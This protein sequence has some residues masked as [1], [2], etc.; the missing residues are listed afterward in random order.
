MMGDVT[1]LPSSRP[2]TKVSA[3]RTTEDDMAELRGRSAPH[4][5]FI[6]VRKQQ[7]EKQAIKDFFE[8]RH[9]GIRFI[10]ELKDQF[11]GQYFILVRCVAI[12]RMSGCKENRAHISEVSVCV[13]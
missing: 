12:I 4:N 1:N 9:L 8:G 11:I 6:Q 7:P 10:E 5:Y 2:E 13:T 3:Q